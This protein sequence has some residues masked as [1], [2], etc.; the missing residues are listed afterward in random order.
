METKRTTAAKTIMRAVGMRPDLGDADI[1]DVRVYQD[2]TGIGCCFTVTPRGWAKIDT[3]DV[4]D[5]LNV[6]EEGH[7]P[8]Y[9][10]DRV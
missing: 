5:A 9:G 4:L 1:V 10:T 8:P 2:V 6:L 7:V 3:A